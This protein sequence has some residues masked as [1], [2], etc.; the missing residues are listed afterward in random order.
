MF[1]QCLRMLIGVTGQETTQV[2][3]LFG[4][5]WDCRGDPG[6]TR[7]QTVSNSTVEKWQGI[8]RRH[9]RKPNCILDT[10]EFRG[11]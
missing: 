2:V 1:T 3:I 6:Y 7:R 8:H 9:A 5:R 11:E 10:N 4:L